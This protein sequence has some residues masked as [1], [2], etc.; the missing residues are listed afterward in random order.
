MVPFKEGTPITEKSLEV[1]IM[2]DKRIRPTGL[3]QWEAPSLPEYRR[4][5]AYFAK[6]GLQLE[7]KLVLTSL[8]DPGIY[9]LRRDQFIATMLLSATPVYG[10]DQRPPSYHMLDLNDPEVF[11]VRVRDVPNV[12]KLNGGPYYQQQLFLYKNGAQTT[13][14]QFG[15]QLGWILDRTNN[16][17][18]RRGIEP[19]PDLPVRR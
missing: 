15:N 4:Q 9:R 18:E 3:I 11:P 19:F 17:L 6:L 12:P 2:H 1:P 10:R 13:D 8:E 16:I 14:Q 5:K 7:P